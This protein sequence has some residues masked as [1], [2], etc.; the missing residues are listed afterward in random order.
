MTNS[1]LIELHH[2]PHAVLPFY[3]HFLPEYLMLI[4]RPFLAYQKSFVITI[5]KKQYGISISGSQRDKTYIATI[6]LIQLVIS[7]RF[8]NG[9]PIVYLHLMLRR[10]YSGGTGAIS[11]LLGLYSLSGKTSY[12]QISWSLEAARWDVIRI[13]S[14]RNFTG[15]FAAEEPV[16]FQGDLQR[17]WYWV[18]ILILFNSP[19]FIWRLGTSECSCRQL[20]FR[21]K[22]NWL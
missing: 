4:F 14:L 18:Y 17:D 1:I 2:V 10:Q 7:M 22:M 20:V 19:S 11:C 13:L 16:R 3:S 5:N 12:R 21:V 9:V 15:S 6:K 8:I